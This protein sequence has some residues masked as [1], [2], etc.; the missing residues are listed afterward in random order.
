MSQPTC[1]ACQAAQTRPHSPLYH[2]TCS[3]CTDRALNPSQKGGNTMQATDTIELE[4][5]PSAEEAAA[6]NAS[7]AAHNAKKSSRVMVFD[8][9]LELADGEMPAKAMDIANATGLAMP[10]VYDSIKELKRRGRIYSDNGAFFPCGEHQETQAVTTTILANGA[11]KVEKGDQVL[12]LNP[13]E[14]RAHYGMGGA[15]IQQIGIIV[16]ERRLDEQQSQIRRLQRQVQRLEDE[17][18]KL[19]PAAQMDLLGSDA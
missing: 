18:K 9:I 19:A 12:D 10:V 16:L 4:H 7:L 6:L 2:A 11:V 1:T 14:A 5:S 3:D 8:A 13:R 15:H 17:V